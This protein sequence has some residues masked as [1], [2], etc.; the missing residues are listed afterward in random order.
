[1]LL[2]LLAPLRFEAQMP[3]GLPGRDSYAVREANPDEPCRFAA[4]Y[5]RIRSNK[6]DP[7][8][9]YVEVEE[10]VQEEPL[11]FAARC[12]QISEQT[13]DGLTVFDR[14]RGF[15]HLI[16]GEPRIGTALTYFAGTGK[17]FGVMLYSKRWDTEFETRALVWR[18]GA[19][20]DVSSQ[21]LAPLRLAAN[22]YVI[23]PQYGRT[24]RVLRW[25][26]D[27][28]RHRGWFTWTGTKFAPV[29]DGAARK[30][31]RCPDSFRYFEPAARRIYCQ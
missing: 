24:F 12:R 22:D 26:G 7:R 4:E 19:W 21:L 6:S 9:A 17:Q 31:W 2:V 5:Q 10:L 30:S 15:L 27:T 8:V 16:F 20:Q 13:E 3:K 14:A 11:G 1:M 28:F 18:D 29:A 23:A 25:D